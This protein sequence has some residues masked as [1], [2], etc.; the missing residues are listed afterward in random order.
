MTTVASG[1]DRSVVGTSTLAARH[2]PHLAPSMADNAVSL[3]LTRDSLA[4]TILLYFALVSISFITFEYPE[5]TCLFSL[6]FPQTR[7]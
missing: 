5:L 2:L 4:V 6:L 7:M 3:L 1:L